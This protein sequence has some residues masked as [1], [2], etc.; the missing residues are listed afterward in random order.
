MIKP[1]LISEIM[2]NKTGYPA[3]KSD[4]IMI[5]CRQRFYYR[6]IVL[7]DD[8][9]GILILSDAS[10]SMNMELNYLESREKYFTMINSLPEIVFEIDSR[11]KI[12]F[13]NR[14]AIEILGYTYDEL[15]TINAFELIDSDKSITAITE[16][17][18]SGQCRVK[19]SH[20]L[21]CK[22]D[23][24][25]PI[26]LFL[27]PMETEGRISGYR[28]IAVDI[29]PLV[30]ARN[31]LLSSE[32]KFRKMIEYSFDAIAIIDSRG[33]LTYI[34]PAARSITGYD[35]DELLGR[36]V[37]DFLAADGKQKVL[38]L[39][40]GPL[41]KSRSTLKGKM[42]FN[43]KNGSIKTLAYNITNLL[44]DDSIKGMVINCHDITQEIEACALIEHQ[45]IELLHRE[46]QYRYLYENA[47]VG[48]FTARLDDFLII[49]ANE[50]CQ[51]LLGFSS[52]KEFV[53]KRR[54]TDFFPDNKKI[55]PLVNNS[56]Q[57]SY[58]HNDAIQMRKNDGSLFWIEI[59]TRIAHFE[60]TVDGIIIDV[61]K[62]KKAEHD[63]Y[64][65]TYYDQL[66]RLPNRELFR[67]H[68]IKE[69]ARAKIKGEG[70]VFAVM[71]LGIDRFKH[72]NSIYGPRIGDQLLKE[73]A[74][75]LEASIYKKD[76]KLSRFEGDKFLILFSDIKDRENAGAL[77]KN[78]GKIFTEP[79]FIDNLYI[80]VTASVG[81]ST[82]PSDGDDSDTLIKNCETALYIAKEQG[83]GMCHFFDSRLNDEML[84]NFEIEKD[85]RKAV[86]KNQFFIHYQPQM[87]RNGILTGLEALIRWQCPKRGL[88]PPLHFIPIA[89]RSGIIVDIGNAV[90][91]Q[92]CGQLKKW[93]KSGL[94]PGKIAI[95]L[96]PY[97]FSQKNL[98]EK[99]M[100]EIV[101]ANIDPAYIELEIT[102][103]GIM[104]N[105]DDSIQKIMKLKEMGFSIAVDDF[106]TGYSSLNKLQNYPIDT[107][108]LD[109][110]FIQNILSDKKS[111][112]ISKHIIQL[113][114]DL[115]FEVVAEGVETKE[116]LEFLIQ[117][118]CDKFQGYY[119]SKPQSPEFLEETFL[120]R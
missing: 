34:S 87:N 67:Q 60:N 93:K 19:H 23:T 49:N 43:N 52:K 94:N 51:H 29:S 110:S 74:M 48:M 1:G 45:N 16:K 104:E 9:T 53:G 71:F 2:N 17:L 115:G 89:E 109:K 76:D 117:H 77:V 85:L 18:L 32:G 44:D 84:N 47:L 82:Y 105:E 103:S 70:Y 69:I 79:F 50:M 72:I 37:W 31:L 59:T 30:E 4:S 98:T 38:Y 6:H 80:D 78:M 92:T 90:L 108:K 26:N 100:E 118:N 25:I 40:E 73:I 27:S 21:K 7:L 97:Q 111:S 13:V 99:V 86:Q 24:L 20:S 58:Y 41:G 95:N 61:S 113:S 11:G 107:L 36:P 83:K 102:E 88:V 68:V 33:V 119:F 116:Q 81:L 28:G 120:A 106:G 63:V 14:K 114:H 65:L 46:S 57:N 39:L 112:A 10:D 75:K 15:N 12:L 96:S 8:K 35:P 101:R 42:Q 3:I 64:K 66:T 56:G 91:A 54:L 22:N 62:R 55:D 5:T